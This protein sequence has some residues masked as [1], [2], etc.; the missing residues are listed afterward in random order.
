VR[1]APRFVPLGTARL[2]AGFADVAKGEE[3][4]VAEVRSVLNTQLLSILFRS[5][6]IS[7]RCVNC[8]SCSHSRLVSLQPT[9]PSDNSWSGCSLQCILRLLE[10]V[11]DQQTT[12]RNGGRLKC[13]P[14]PGER[15]VLLYRNCTKPS[16]YG[17][18]TR[19][20]YPRIADHPPLCVAGVNYKATLVLFSERITD[21]RSLADSVVDLK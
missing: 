6:L 20:D 10:A 4:L 14:I 13:S 7:R 3:I 11:F 18:N 9:T 17:D 15:I 19:L 16:T 5:E 21:A 1:L 2:V 8:T 12:K